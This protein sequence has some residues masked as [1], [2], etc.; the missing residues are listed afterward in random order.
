[1]RK[2]GPWL[3][4]LGVLLGVTLG[5]LHVRKAP[6]VAAPAPAAGAAAPLPAFPSVGV[7]ATREAGFALAGRVLDAAGAPV[8]GAEVSLAATAQASLAT[9][10]CDEDGQ[11]LLLC[12]ARETGLAL[13]ALLERGEGLLQPGARTRSGPD[14][15]FRF[16]G[17][18]G[19]SFTVWAAAPG[20]GAAVR[21]RAAPGEP[22]ELFLPP[23]RALEGQVVDEG[24]GAVPGARVWAVSRRLPLGGDV[25]AGGD[26]RFRVEG[27]GEGPFTLVA[28]APGFLPVTLGPVEA[29]GGGALQLVLARPRTLEVEVQRGGAPAEAR[30]RLEADHLRRE[31]ATREG[32]VRFEGL[33]PGALGLLARAEDGAASAPQKVLLREAVTRVTLALEPGG[34]LLVTVVDEA[35]QPVPAPT[36]TLWTPSGERVEERRAGTG[37]LVVLGPQGAGDYV[38]EGRAEGFP[39]VE[40]PVKLA[41]GDLPL[42]LTLRRGTLLAGRVLDMYGR[43]APGVSVLVQP[44]GSSALSDGEG[45]FSTLV[46]SPGLYTLHA[47][48]SDWGGA[49]K[50]V[51]A[52]DTAVELALEPGA[53]LEVVAQSGG[54]RVEGASAMAWLDNDNVFRS[55]RTSGADGRVPLRGLP[56]GT[57]QVTASHPDHLPS[58]RQKVT[59]QEGQ[60]LTVTAELAAGAR[61]EGEVVDEEGQAVPRAV[62]AVFPR[63][64]PGTQSDARG[65]FTLR[66]LPPGRPFRLEAFHAEYEQEAPL[67]LTA[68]EGGAPPVRV[69]MKRR[70]VFRGRVLAEDGQPVRRYTVNEREVL[71]A[72]GRFALPL[73]AREGAGGQLLLTVE[74]PGFEPQV[75]ERPSQPD[76]GDVVLKRAATLTGQVREASGSPVAEAVVTCDLCDEGALSGPDGRFTLSRPAYAGAFTLTARKGPMSG[77]ATVARGQASVE[78]TLAPAAPLAGTAF[79]ADGRPAAGVALV[80][81]SPDTPEDRVAVTAADGRYTLELAPGV[82]R[83]AQAPEATVYG[84]GP[85]VQVRVPEGGAQ[86]DLGGTPGS[87]SLAVRL[88]PE[89]G[90]ALWLV[91]GE[92]GP[93]AP[94]QLASLPLA[95]VAFQPREARVLFRGL[96]PGRYTLVWAPLYGGTG[97]TPLARPVDVGR[98]AEVD[99]AGGS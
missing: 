20:L 61:L 65:R 50:R 58:E 89:K 52:P 93:L 7:H 67:P 68:G 92:P 87:A 71:S 43:P 12:P 2:V 21:E 78:L 28:A 97:G 5:V 40:L 46:P 35:G 72:D 17:L 85:V 38:L 48:H 91:P 59:V 19:V 77:R 26:G 32:R 30:V 53:S 94:S 90:R 64:A 22:V 16:E 66:A 10:P 74:A 1:M 25:R 4:A 54:R 80:V 73:G 95:H 36:V 9:V 33:Y 96:A 83:V 41:A 18:S 13:L 37:E 34:R 47:H 8:A 44:L 39:E 27:L 24:G 49:E 69:V 23:P 3:L 42:E 88:T 55:D 86:L 98:Q 29:G 99:L 45:R 15:T 84:G 57:Y 56:P 51:G 11:P 82:Y 76:L 62:V 81:S 31:A 14:G 60:T 63:L 79:G 6:P 75:V 70:A